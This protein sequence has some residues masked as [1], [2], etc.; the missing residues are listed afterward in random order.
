[1]PADQCPDSVKK[2]EFLA[3]DKWAERLYSQGLQSDDRSFCPRF[4]TV[5]GDRGLVTMD[6]SIGSSAKTHHLT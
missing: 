5:T 1:M 2:S 6:N 4:A 3:Q